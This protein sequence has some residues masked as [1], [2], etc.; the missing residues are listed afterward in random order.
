MEWIRAVEVQ[1]YVNNVELRANGYDS[2]IPPRWRE[3]HA[4]HQAMG[5]SSQCQADRPVAP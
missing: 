5:S 2:Y 1:H 3:E 4:R